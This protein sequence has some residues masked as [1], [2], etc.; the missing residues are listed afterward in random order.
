MGKQPL[1]A[2]D[3]LVYLTVYI[4]YTCTKHTQRVYADSMHHVLDRSLC[5]ISTNT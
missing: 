2:M 5:N 3:A 1:S 4:M